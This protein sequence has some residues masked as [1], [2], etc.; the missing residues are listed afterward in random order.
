MSEEITNIEGITIPYYVEL[1]VQLREPCCDNS[2]W[3][4]YS[5][6]DIERMT[7]RLRKYLFK[8]RNCTKTESFDEKI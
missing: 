2:V 4:L 6:R 7:G 5:Y 3:Y 1:M 8:C